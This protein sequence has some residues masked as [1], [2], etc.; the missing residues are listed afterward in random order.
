MDKTTEDATYVAGDAWIEWK[1]VEEDPEGYDFK[2]VTESVGC[3]IHGLDLA[4]LRI[5]HADFKRLTK[6]TEEMIS[7]KVAAGETEADNA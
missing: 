5:A 7:R 3:D 1:Y 6:E 4:Q 2:T